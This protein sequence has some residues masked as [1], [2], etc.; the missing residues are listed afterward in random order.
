MKKVVLLCIALCTL[1]SVQAQDF[2]YSKYVNYTKEQFLA[3]NFKYDKR[4]NTWYISKSNGLNVAVNILAII[5]DAY[6][7]VRPSYDDYTIAVQLGEEDMVASVMV[8]FYNDETYHKLLTFVKDNGEKYV[9]TS[10][11][12]IVKQQAF[13]NNYALELQ[14]EQY[15]ISRTSSYTADSRTVMNVD[16]SYNEYRF[17]ISTGVE[18]R[19]KYL[20]KQAAKKAKREE[21][22][23]KLELEDMM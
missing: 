1:F 16:E 19:S 17:T 3:S 9:E 15:I 7:E 10:S 13:Y 14:M 18:P 22:G 11:G 2:P 12:K 21:K 4:A 6:D 23:R 20:D 5:A 8:E